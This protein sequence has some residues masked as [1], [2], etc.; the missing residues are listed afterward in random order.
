MHG[1]T[2]AAASFSRRL[3]KVKDAGGDLEPVIEKMN[4]MA[5]EKYLLVY[6]KARNLSFEIN[7]RCTEQFLLTNALVFTRT[8]L[9]NLLVGVTFIHFSRTLWF[10]V[11][12]VYCL[13][14]D[15]ELL[16]IGFLRNWQMW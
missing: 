9:V 16:L 8:V 6:N 10:T 11:V 12:D 15:V 3:V 2:A 4:K 13:Y 7:R 5:G 14:A 1:E